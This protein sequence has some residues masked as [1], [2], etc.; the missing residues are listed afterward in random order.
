MSYRDAP[1][2]LVITSMG[3]AL[4]A[5]D[6]QDGTIV[7][8]YRAR[9]TITRL[10]RVG[11]RVMVICGT[12]VHCVDR[13]TGRPIGR[14]EL[15]FRPECGCVVGSDLVLANG[16]L[17][18]GQ[19]CVVR[20]TSEGTLRWRATKDSRSMSFLESDTIVRSFGP[21]GS[22]RSEI[23]LEGVVGARAGLLVGDTVVQP[24]DAE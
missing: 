6:L 19:P 7:W 15:D 1:Q 13:E 10:Y 2:E 21:D 4:V 23:V 14:L 17:V 24:D 22:Q 3:S 11:D 8:S 20:L 16:Q 9:V 18:G 12:E 5:F